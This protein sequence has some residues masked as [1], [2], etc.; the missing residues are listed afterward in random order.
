M[1]MTASIATLNPG[2]TVLG[3]PVNFV[4]TVNNTGASNFSVTEIQPTVIFNGNTAALDGSSV[5]LGK[6]FLNGDVIQPSTSKDFYFSVAFNVPSI[7]FDHTAGSYLVNCK[8]Q[9]TL[10][11]PNVVGAS[12]VT[13]IVTQVPKE[14]STP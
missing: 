5:E 14:A 1:S 2:T 4:V 6:V 10:G 12:P 8:V 3:Q 9:N 13:M 11:D 7:N